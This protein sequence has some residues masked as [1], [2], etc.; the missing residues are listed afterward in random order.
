MN[1]YHVWKLMHTIGH[2]MCSLSIFGTSHPKSAKKAKQ[3]A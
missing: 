1:A 3:R 2:I